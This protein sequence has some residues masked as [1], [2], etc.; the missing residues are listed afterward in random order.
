MA[1]VKTPNDSDFRVDWA[2]A[3]QQE[4]FACRD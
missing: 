2:V 3:E 1:T 4:R